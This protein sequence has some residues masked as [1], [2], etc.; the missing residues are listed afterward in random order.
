MGVLGRA[1]EG[2]VI[3]QLEQDRVRQLERW[4]MVMIG[5]VLGVAIGLL[6]YSLVRHGK[7]QDGQDGEWGVEWDY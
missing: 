7:G 3:V 1:E 2:R 6:V 5:I 4:G